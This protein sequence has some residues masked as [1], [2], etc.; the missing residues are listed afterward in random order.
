MPLPQRYSHGV[1]VTEVSQEL[2]SAL[3]GELGHVRRR[4]RRRVGRPFPERALTGAQ[5]DLLGVVRRAPAISVAAAAAEL[6]VAAN[7][8]STLVGQLVEAGMLDRSSD[9]ADRRVA[10]LHLTAAAR[11]RVERWRD[12]RVGVVAD[13]LAR[14]DR[15]DVDVLAGAVPALARLADELVELEGR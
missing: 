1:A 7:T 12:E 9:P 5:A 3:L 11:Q 15:A 14:L 13:A 8:V 6:G 10:R 4:V 2:A